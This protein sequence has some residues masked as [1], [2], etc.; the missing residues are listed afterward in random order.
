MHRKRLLRTA[1][2]TEQ[3]FR[4]FADQQPDMPKILFVAAHRPDRSPSQRFRF[5]QYMPALREQGFTYD[6]SY[7][8]SEK[9]D[10]VF[11]QPGHLLT[12]GYIF[13]KSYLRRL[14]DV[15]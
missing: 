10:R 12:K 8:I 13:F 14:Q 9:D 4:F 1:G 6:F 5:E 3:I 2:K 11:Y 7:L 15:W